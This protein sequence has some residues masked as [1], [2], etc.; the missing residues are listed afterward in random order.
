[1]TWSLLI[2]KLSDEEIVDFVIAYHK[3]K[4]GILKRFVV[5]IIGSVCISYLFSIELFT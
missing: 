4:T 1:M 2:V 3:V 5:G